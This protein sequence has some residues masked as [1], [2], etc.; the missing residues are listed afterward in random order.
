MVIAGASLSPAE[1]GGAHSDKEFPNTLSMQKAKDGQN[2]L[3]TEE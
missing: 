3:R 1:E 2:H